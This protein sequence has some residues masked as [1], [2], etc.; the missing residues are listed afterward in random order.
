M[1]CLFYV[2]ACYPIFTVYIRGMVGGMVMIDGGGV[3]GGGV[4]DGG[5]GEVGGD[6][7][8]GV[9]FLCSSQSHG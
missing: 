1:G 5:D 4:V 6:G 8:I 9:S 2:G 3:V 7:G